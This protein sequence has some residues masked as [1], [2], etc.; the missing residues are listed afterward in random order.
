MYEHLPQELKDYPYFYGWRYEIVKG[1][2]T[3]VP[4]SVKGHNAD[5][6]N[7]DEF[8]PLDEVIKHLD[9]CDG[10][11]IAL[12]GGI[13]AIDIDH[14]ICDGKLSA[15]AEDII[16]KADSYTEISPSGECVRILAKADGFVYDADKYYIHNHALGLEV[17]AA[18][19]KGYV[20][21]TGNVIHNKPVRDITD[22]LPEI[23]E[24]Y[25]QRPVPKRMEPSVEAPGSF[26]TDDE[27]IDKALRSVNGD[28]FISLYDGDISGYPSQS[29]AE[30]AFMT[31]LAFW[32]GGDEEQME[33]IY[34]GSRLKREKWNRADYRNSTISKALRG[35][36][37]F[38]KP[39]STT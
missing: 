35:V 33:R 38:Y 32:C 26:L 4:K 8:A 11:G 25:M 10:I 6:R 19:D 13:A 29:E 5:T 3:K 16:A 39:I 20:T 2:R 23:L 22:V 18:R 9:K 15:M 1:N 12:A 34:L 37:D 21:V 24:K 28:K 17:Y 7:L 14:C 27:V 31:M 36:T 30:L